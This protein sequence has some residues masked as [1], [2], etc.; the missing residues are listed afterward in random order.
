MVLFELPRP[1][2]GGSCKPVIT[3]TRELLGLRASPRLLVIICAVQALVLLG[4]TWMQIG[5]V[6]CAV[7]LPTSG[8][9]VVN[10]DSCRRL[11]LTWRGT[12][13]LILGLGVISVGL[14]AVWRHDQRLLFV[15]GSCMV[16]FGP[17]VELNLP[18]SRPPVP[19]TPAPSPMAAAFSVGLNSV[20][21]AL[22]TPLLEVA[23][24]GVADDLECL[25]M[26]YSMMFDAR[27]HAAF[28]A[29]GCLVDA[30]G[31]LLAIRAKELFTYE[32]ISAQH[33]AASR[34]PR[35]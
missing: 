13:M 1:S 32:D 22:E 21:T 33:S 9:M 16:F 2:A 27:G 10:C 29:L 18:P 11:G 25:E 8:R 12:F 5:R 14:S 20:L 6:D 34:I 28:A 7:E 17:R 30:L 26:A 15:Y 3:L 4:G 31:A 19:R 35:L 24:E 23:V